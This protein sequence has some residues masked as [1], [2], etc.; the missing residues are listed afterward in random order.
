MPRHPLRPA[1]ALIA[2]ALLTA[3]CG[4]TTVAKVQESTTITKG[5]ELTDLLRA[6]NEGA[7]TEREYEWLRG[8]ILQRPQ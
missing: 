6:L 2:A 1:A 8:R 7:I 5:Q 3:A 4:S